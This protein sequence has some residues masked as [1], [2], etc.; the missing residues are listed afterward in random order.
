MYYSL[1][2][3]ISWWHQG[4]P[5]F[6]TIGEVPPLLQEGEGVKVVRSYA[7]GLLIDPAM[8]KGVYEVRLDL[9]TA[10][11]LCC[12]EVRLMDSKRPRYG[13]SD[14]L[15]RPELKGGRILDEFLE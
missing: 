5:C 9:L 4:K 1:P 8:P 12:A 7:Y 2:V 10:K 6:T 13:E 14:N 3:V 11:N 15:F